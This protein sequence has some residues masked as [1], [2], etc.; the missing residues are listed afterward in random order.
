MTS[1]GKLFELKTKEVFEGL[2]RLDGLKILDIKHDVK[3]VGLSGAEH[4]IDVYIRFELFGQENQTVVEAKDFQSP[5]DKPRLMTFVGVLQDLPGRPNGMFVTRSGFDSGNIYPI[6]KAHNVGLYVLEEWAGQGPSFKLSVIQHFAALKHLALAEG[7]NEVL[8]EEFNGK[9]AAEL[10]LYDELGVLRATVQTL[11]DQAVR[12]MIS[13]NVPVGQCF[14][15]NLNDPHALYFHTGDQNEPRVRVLG[16]VFER[17]QQISEQEG[18]NKLTHLLSLLTGNKQYFVDA[19]GKVW[20][21]G[22]NMPITFEFPSIGPNGE[23]VLVDVITRLPDP[24]S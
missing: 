22:G 21:A 13:S 16:A 10:L 4:Q 23:D 12:F 8:L 15:V 11:L 18:G 2:A 14:S 9:R 20:P 17:Q 1:P 6:A 5:V 7:A 19:N 24:Q 3:I